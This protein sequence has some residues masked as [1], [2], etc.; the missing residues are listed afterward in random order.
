MPIYSFD[1]HQ[2]FNNIDKIPDFRSDEEKLNSPLSL[3]NHQSNDIAYAER[4]AEELINLSGAWITVFKRRRASNRDDVWE[5]DPDPTYKNGIKIKGMFAPEPAEITLS[6]FGVDVENNVTI[7]FSRSNVMKLFNKAMIAEGDVLL[8]PHNTMTVVQNIDLR[9]GP[10]NRVE[11]FRVLKS[12]DT[13]NFKYRWL[14][15]TVV[16]Q[17]ITGDETIDVTFNKDHA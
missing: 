16:A 5:E 8:V 1:K 7:H 11:K 2:E 12:S 17:N 15:W 9:D 14:Y 13:G 10:G 4:T 6:R 3:Y